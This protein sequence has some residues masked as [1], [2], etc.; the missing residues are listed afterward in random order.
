MTIVYAIEAPDGR[1]EAIGDEAF[2]RLVD[3]LQAKFPTA[4]LNITGRLIEDRSVHRKLSFN[5]IIVDEHEGA[6]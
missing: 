3:Q 5:A 6:A 4:E 1:H 2:D